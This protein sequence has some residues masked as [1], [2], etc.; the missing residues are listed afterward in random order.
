MVTAGERRDRVSVQVRTE[1]SDGHD[2]YTE[3]WDTRHSR[4]SARARALS[5]RDLERARQVDPRVSWEVVFGYW[6]AFRADLDGGRARLLVHPT[7][8]SADDITLEIVTPPVDVEGKRHD[9][10][11]L[12]R[13]AA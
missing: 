12:C 10:L 1:T 4:W 11:V 13:E 7:S 9:V 6:R 8:N 5:G 3:T 2:G